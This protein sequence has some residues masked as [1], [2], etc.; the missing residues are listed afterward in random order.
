MTIRLLHTAD[1][2]LGKSFARF[3]GGDLPALLR[4]A[5][6]AAVERLAALANEADVAAVLVAG[7]ILDHE[8]AE[9]GLLRR[10]VHRM[11]GFAGPWLLLPG[12]HDPARPGGVWD[13]FAGSGDCPANIRLL[14]EPEPVTLLDGRLAV[15][16]APLRQKHV[17]GDTT[18]WFDT[19]AVPAGAVKVGLAHGGVP[20]LLPGQSESQNP[21]ARDR[22]ERAGLDYLALG[23]WHSVLQ[24]GPRTW[25]S[26]TPEP[27]D[28]TRSGRGQALLVTLAGPGQPA[29]VRTLDTGRHAWHARKVDLGHG[30]DE[31]AIGD[32]LDALVAGLAAPGDTV[33][34]LTLEGAL[35]LAGRAALEAA[36]GRLEARLRHLEARDEGLSTA[37][38][39]ADLSAMAGEPLLA[40][41]VSALAASGDPA[42]PVA[43][44]LLHQTWQRLEPG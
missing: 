43:L 27:D 28:F 8:H 14:G 38:S 13:R 18:E 34:R 17:S 26:G 23:D 44:R 39:E 31:R 5:R 37:A 19:A 6:L 3:A 20:E 30:A 12:N 25:F 42:A 9:P 21:I 16:P 22:A 15:L 35:D 7:D 10:M 29:A 40:E 2:Q 1:W 33:L 36:L 24:V 11:A 41:V 4:E 32:Q